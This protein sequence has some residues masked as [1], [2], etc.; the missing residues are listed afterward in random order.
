M[1]KYITIGCLLV[2][3]SAYAQPTFNKVY[4]EGFWATNMVTDGEDMVMAADFRSNAIQYGIRWLRIDSSGAIVREDSVKLPG[5]EDV[6]SGFWGSLQVKPN[7]NLLLVGYTRTDSYLLEVTP[8]FDSV[9]SRRY[10]YPTG[11][12]LFFSATVCANGDIAVTG[13]HFHLPAGDSISQKAILVARFD[14]SFNLLW[15]TSLGEPKRMGR[16]IAQLGG[17]IIEM[18]DSSLIVNANR[19]ID[20]YPDSGD[21]LLL[22]YDRAGNL[23]WRKTIGSPVHQDGTARLLQSTD[24]SF[25]LAYARGVDRFRFGSINYRET[26]ITLGEYGLDSNLYWEKTYGAKALR[27]GVLAI[28]RVDT[29]LV[30]LEAEDDYST[31]VTYASARGVSLEGDSLWHVP[32]YSPDTPGLRVGIFYD[33]AVSESGALLMGGTAEYTVNFRDYK[34]VWCVRTDGEGCFE[35]GCHNIGLKEPAAQIGLEVYPNPAN[36]YIR[37]E[38]T[39]LENKAYPL[40]VYNTNGQLVLNRRF[41]PGTQIDVRALKPGLYLLEVADEAGVFR[42]ALLVDD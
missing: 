5:N 24:T 3:G 17:Q 42:A 4:K 30:L 14:S 23:L 18:P 2:L 9:R 40:K 8:Q 16:N 39:G 35:S 20:F 12:S 34:Q 41:F 7:G 11:R 37:V 29:T 21:N 25:Y 1:K 26:V 15:E 13:E 10:A 22:R 36:A 28:K 32:V 33:L 19:Y 38:G 31:F 6:Y 27:K